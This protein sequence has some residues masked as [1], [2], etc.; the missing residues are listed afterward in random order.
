MEE[1]WKK[2]SCKE[3]E[4]R[5]V[6]L[7]QNLRTTRVADPKARKR[8]GQRQRQVQ[9]QRQRQRWTSNRGV[10]DACDGPEAALARATSCFF[11]CPLISIYIA[12]ASTN[13]M[14]ATSLC[15][16]QSPYILRLQ[17]PFIYHNN[18]N[19]NARPTARSVLQSPRPCLSWHQAMMTYILIFIEGNH[20][21]NW[22]SKQGL[23]ITITQASWM[24]ILGCHDGKQ[25]V[26]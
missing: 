4:R 26:L 25:T 23:S 13:S 6:W 19:V 22:S 12:P 11:L 9:R 10:T 15:N 21:I 7:L 17:P 20:H 14:Q 24:P 3:K 5:G 1:K 2:S 18:S 16:A 8:Q